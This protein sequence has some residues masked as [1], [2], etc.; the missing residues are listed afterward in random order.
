FPQL[1]AGGFDGVW[2][3]GPI[4]PVG[5]D[6]PRDLHRQIC[7]SEL[8]QDLHVVIILDT[9]AQPFQPHRWHYALNAHRLARIDEHPFT[10]VVS[11]AIGARVVYVVP[12]VGWP[13]VDAPVKHSAEV[14]ALADEARLDA[15][16]DRVE[17][18]QPLG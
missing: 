4:G 9:V 2:V 16:V 12:G 5:A 10:R 17:I 8:L 18:D 15:E 3:A 13:F 7:L 11:R 14:E 1:L 6:G